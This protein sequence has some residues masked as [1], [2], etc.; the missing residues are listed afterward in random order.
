[1]ATTKKNRN[2]LIEFLG[3]GWGVFLTALSIFSLGFGAGCYV[4][5]TLTTLKHYED[6]ASHANEMLEYRTQKEKE[7]FEL[8]SKIN[9]L[10]SDLLK[11]QNTKEYEKK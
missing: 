6:K 2:K 8:R 1:M 4:N 9:Q 7:I 10:Q 3:T 5:N 11:Q